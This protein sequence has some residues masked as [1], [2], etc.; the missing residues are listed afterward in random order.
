MP[1]RSLCDHPFATVPSGG[2]VSPLTSD[3]TDPKTSTLP[4]R[5]TAGTL[6]AAGCL[7]GFMRFE[8]DTSDTL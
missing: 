4:V 8:Q 2:Q 5:A 6:C 7:V 1:F 3:P